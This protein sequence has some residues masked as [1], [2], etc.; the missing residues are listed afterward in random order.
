M[1]LP[2]TAYPG[3][4]RAPQSAVGLPQQTNK[5]AAP[6]TSL[7]QQCL[8]LA[9][10]L[11]CVPGF[12]IYLD[13]DVNPDIVTFP[14]GSLSPASD[15]VKALWTAF[16][17]GAALC[18]LY[19][20]GRPKEPLEVKD[21]DDL[22][23]LNDCKKSVYR[24]LLACKTE[25]QF[26]DNQLFSISEL[27]KDDTNGFVK[28]VQV[29]SEIVDRLEAQDLLVRNSPTSIRL[30]TTKRRSEG[31]VGNREKVVTELLETE[32]KYVSDLEILQDYM[33]QLERNEIVPLA[34]VR[35]MFLNL[36]SLVD[37]QRK[38]L[39]GVEANAQLPQADQ[40]FGTLFLQM[41][42]EFAVYE[43]FCGNYA[44]ASDIV[45]EEASNLMK[46]TNVLEPTHALPALL[47]KPVQ[48][49]C[50]YPLLLGEL[51]KYTDSGAAYLLGDLTAGR[52]AIKRVADR[53]NE[54]RRRQ[55]N[56]ATVVDLTLRVLDWKGHRLDS[57]GP[58]LLSEK[59]VMV[60][61]DFERELTVYL[62][63]KIILL[64][65]ESGSGKKL[66]GSAS[67]LF[68]RA[69]KTPNSRRGSLH[70]KGRIYTSSV[71]GVIN[72]SSNGQCTLKVFWA[73][74]EMESFS[75]QCRNE[76]QLNLWK[77]TLARVVE[78]ENG[79]GGGSSSSGR[80]SLKSRNTVSAPNLDPQEVGALIAS[81]RSGRYS[82]RVSAARPAGGGEYQ[83]RPASLVPSLDGSN[84]QSVRSTPASPRFHQRSASKTYVLPDEEQLAATYADLMRTNGAAAGEGGEA[85][86]GGDT[87]ELE[88]QRR[89][90][91]RKRSQSSPDIRDIMS[92]SPP[93]PV[94]R[95]P[96]A[97]V[98][99][100]AG[101]AAAPAPAP[102]AA[103]AKLVKM[104]VT[105]LDDIFVIS[106]PFT[107]GYEDLLA[108]IVKKLRIAGA[109][110]DGDDSLR[111]RYLD[112][113]DYITINCDE[114]VAMAFEGAANGGVVHV[115]ADK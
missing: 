72:S 104:K 18:A 114:D 101:Q 13:P 10:R 83:F 76:E 12:E 79:G 113:G 82:S 88:R 11:L 37:F 17:T 67:Q 99:S 43:P 25:L 41:E 107:A 50:K 5:P 54:E 39:M 30:S 90:M 20:G 62:F 34:T 105:Y 8:H 19:N 61:Q 48:R 102:A 56:A 29:V 97:L 89:Q 33:K 40:R 81:E 63:Q 70:L 14:D 73:D 49:I 60:T 7:Y 45:V 86:E 71:T 78:E 28:V 16:R 68:Q 59:F 75:L 24:F 74:A 27:Y 109:F 53:V 108:R 6:P 66:S 32:R 38:F 1:A 84:R 55:D 95:L 103:P 31:P 51:I 87:L 112:D 22:T 96:E 106:V 64:C 58:L 110:A 52:D 42:E 36:D 2:P 115:F 3:Q 35:K 92:S 26:R 91:F 9:G 15:P 93:P 94:P 98:S 44:V 69:S 77:D 47:I 111:L 4:G 21:L 46:M 85:P 57:F 65:K 23:S 80:P 100:A